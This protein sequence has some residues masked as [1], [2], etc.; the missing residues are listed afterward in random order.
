MFIHNFRKSFIYI[1]IVIVPDVNL[2]Y[3]R[4]EQRYRSNYNI[5]DNHDK[6]RKYGEINKNNIDTV[7]QGYR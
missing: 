1:Y 4:D 3:Y 5:N 7:L 6:N 2:I